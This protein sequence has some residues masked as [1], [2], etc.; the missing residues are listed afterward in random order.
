MNS[1]KNMI[2]SIKPQNL[3][4]WLM[5]SSQSTFNLRSPGFYLARSYLIATVQPIFRQFETYL[6]KIIYN[7]EKEEDKWTVKKFGANMAQNLFLNY[8]IL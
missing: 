5:K 1:F 4:P 8:I 6:E 2:K 3:G 7:N